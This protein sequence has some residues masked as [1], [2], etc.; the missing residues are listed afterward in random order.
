MKKEITTKLPAFFEKLNNPIVEKFAPENREDY[1][2]K[3]K[4][5]LIIF[6]SSDASMDNSSEVSNY[7]RLIIDVGLNPYTGYPLSPNCNGITTIGNMNIRDISYSTH[8]NSDEIKDIAYDLNNLRTKRLV[9]RERF[10]IYAQYVIE[11]V[12][13]LANSRVHDRLASIPKLD[14]FINPDSYFNYS[15]VLTNVFSASI[16]CKFDGTE[17]YTGTSIE[18]LKYGNLSALYDVEYYWYNSPITLYDIVLNGVMKNYNVFLSAMRCNDIP[19]E[20]VNL[21]D[22]YTE[23][24]NIVNEEQIVLLTG[25]ENVITSLYQL[26]KEYSEA[27]LP[28]FV[29]CSI[30]DFGLSHIAAMP[31]EQRSYYDE[32]LIKPFTD[33]GE[34]DK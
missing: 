29:S 14:K 12:I 7:R 31:E 22:Y 11:Q 3:D 34:S 10:A 28:N 25:L 19:L 23:I 24:L 16:I 18:D 9:L 8:G 27:G 13:S 21:K 33:D 1:S 15:R 4:S 20:G 5:S 2:S 26:A 30:D 32:K 6:D 17:D